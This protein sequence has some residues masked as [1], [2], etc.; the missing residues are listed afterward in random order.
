MQIVIVVAET[1]VG[2]ELKTRLTVILCFTPYFKRP[3]RI[4][5]LLLSLL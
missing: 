5:V 4:D 3:A 2:G 1:I